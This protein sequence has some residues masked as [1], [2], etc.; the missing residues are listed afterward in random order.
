M[1]K[2]KYPKSGELKIVLSRLTSE[3]VNPSFGAFFSGAARVY[4]TGRADRWNAIPVELQDLPAALK[5]HG[6]TQCKTRRI[7]RPCVLA[8]KNEIYRLDLDGWRPACC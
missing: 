8:I 2:L 3:N 4:L 7:K 1:N 5:T 6:E